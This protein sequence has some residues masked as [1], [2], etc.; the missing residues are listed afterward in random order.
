MQHLASEGFVDLPQ[1]DIGGRQAKALEQL[2]YRQHGPDAH[3]LWGA[4]GHRDT[5]VDAQR[6]QAMLSGLG[7]AHQ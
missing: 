2:G 3:L 4:T 1:A 7:A 5:S 6:L